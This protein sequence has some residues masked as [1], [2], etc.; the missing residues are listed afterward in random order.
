MGKADEFLARIEALNYRLMSGWFCR[1]LIKAPVTPA[2]QTAARQLPSHPDENPVTLLAD[3]TRFQL[4]ES[5]KEMH[6]LRQRLGGGRS[7]SLAT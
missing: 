1:D 7:V 5:A 3:Q 6:S 2:G 4:L